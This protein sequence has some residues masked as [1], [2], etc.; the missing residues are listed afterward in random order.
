MYIYFQR[1]VSKS[2]I[3]N[4]ILIHWYIF[5]VAYTK[6]LENIEKDVKRKLKISVST[7]CIKKN[8]KRYINFKDN[9]HE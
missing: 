7:Q 1:F 9:M 5:N 2:N 8:I 4:S 6:L 3:T